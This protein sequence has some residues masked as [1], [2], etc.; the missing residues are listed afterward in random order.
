MKEK[1]D[2]KGLDLL[3][4]NLEDD[5]SEDDDYVPDAKA[6]NNAEKE[7]LKQNGPA[8]H[9]DVKD[10]SGIDLLKQKKR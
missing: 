10:L 8:K 1:K 7:L 9:Q 6:H 5:S 2:K 4:D 3:N